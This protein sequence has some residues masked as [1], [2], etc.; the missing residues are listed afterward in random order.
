MKTINI[1]T[2]GGSRGNP[3]PA[4]IGVF[5]ESGGKTLAE[6]GETIGETTNNFAEYSA[7]LR[8]LDFLLSSKDLLESTSNISFFMDSQLVSSQIKGTYKVKSSTLAELLLKIREKEAQIRIPI[9]Y[10][11]IPREKNKK[12]DKLVNLAL[13]N[14]LRVG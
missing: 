13:D 7:V 10:K 8:G 2:D 6:I 1:Y 3:G 14:K 9:F 12:A 4:A 5:I 11:F